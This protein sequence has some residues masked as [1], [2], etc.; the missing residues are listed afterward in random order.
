MRIEQEF[1]NEGTGLRRIS[2]YFFPNFFSSGESAYLTLFGRLQ[3]AISLSQA[4]DLPKKDIV[5]FIDEGDAG[6]HPKW[7]KMFLKWILDYL[8]NIDNSLRFQLIFSTHSPY[9]LSDLASQNTILLHRGTNGHTEILRNKDEGTFGANIH[10]LLSDSFFMD[11]GTVG[12]FAKTEINRVIDQLNEWLITKS[13]NPTHQLTRVTRK[14]R[15]K[16]WEII[17][18]IGDR[19][20]RDKLAE[21]YMDVFQDQESIQ[22]EIAYLENRIKNLKRNDRNT[23]G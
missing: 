11:D 3:H 2:N 17:R 13:G 8:N 21:M 1:M 18:I 6:F 16:T 10:E 7:S 14:E 5:I 22:E 9:L 23:R 4:M 20:V 12:E 15:D 19:I